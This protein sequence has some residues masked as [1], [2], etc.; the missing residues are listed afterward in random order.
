MLIDIVKYRECVLWLHGIQYTIRTFIKL[1]LCSDQ[2]I[3]VIE[4]NELLASKVTIASHRTFLQEHFLDVCVDD[5]L[6]WLHS[7][8]YTGYR[9]KCVSKRPEWIEGFTTK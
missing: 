6:V 2:N 4:I 1:E 7:V 5:V 3:S 9:C 8:L